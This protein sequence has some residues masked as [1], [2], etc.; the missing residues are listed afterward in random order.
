LTDHT[1]IIAALPHR[2]GVYRMLG[3]AGEVLYVGKA[4]D[5]KKRVGS[6]FHNRANH[7]PR[8]RLMVGQVAT[9]ETTVTRSESEA[10]LLENNLIK[11][12][13][14]RYNI[15]FR[16]DKSYPYI[17]LTG[18][19]FARLAFHRGPLDRENRYFGPFPSAGAVRDSIQLLQRVFRVRTCRESVFNNRS[20]PCLLHQIRRCTAPCV[21]LIEEA[22]YADDVRDAALFLE[23]REEEVVQA[24]VERMQA[25]AERMEYERAAAY[26][27]QIQALRKVRETQ[28]VDRSGGKDFDVVAC[29]SAAG[30]VAVN[31]VMIRGGRHLGDKT[32]FPRNADETETA[33]VLEAFLAQHYLDHPP[34][35]RILVNAPV[36]EDALGQFLSAQSGRTVTIVSAPRGE[37]KVWLDMAAQNAT[38]AAEQHVALQATQEARA[39]AL[40][41]GLDLP[42]PV[43]RVEC[44]DVSHT[45]GEATVASCVVYEAGAMKKADYRRFN[46]DAAIAGDDYAAM[47]EVLERRYRRVVDEGGTLPDLIL[48]DGGKGQLGVAAAVMDELGLAEIPLVG[49]SKGEERKPG[50]EQL[51]VRGREQPVILAPTHSGLHLVQQVRD[52][53]HRFAITGHRARRAK[54]RTTSILDEI[55][56]IGAKRRQRLMVR[57]GGLKGLLAASV[58]DITQVEGISRDLA[59]KIYQQLH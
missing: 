12:L 57:F 33:Q 1:E 13:T 36:D 19:R 6:Y 23:G 38:L 30:L 28:F 32:F 43:N 52:E 50:L 48:I 14:P 59:E 49:V 18:H 29:A 3:A 40:Q 45:M 2:P 58:D 53:A 37:R 20:R 9:I 21:G 25:C 17:T 31:L 56:G 16:D 7:S 10:L 35:A 5:L 34:P 47:R 11:A 44:F 15:L 55:A 24:L 39:A 8:I 26:R 54:A 51:W 41:Q 42:E 46:I 22:A 4:L 27:D